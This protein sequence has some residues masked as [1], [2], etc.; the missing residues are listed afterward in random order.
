M[1]LTL[2]MWRMISRV[3]SP[4]KV[5]GG[6]TEGYGNPL[7]IIAFKGYVVHPGHAEN[8]QQGSIAR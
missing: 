7:H 6:W 1:L 4:G 5:G 2:V 3:L 8:D